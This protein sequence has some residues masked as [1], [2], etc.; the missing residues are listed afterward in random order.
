MKK[1][2]TGRTQ[3]K[4]KENKMNIRN[5]EQ[6]NIYQDKHNKGWIVEIRGLF[7]FCEG[8]FQ[9]HKIGTCGTLKAAKEMAAKALNL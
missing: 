3:H 9:W 5:H 6:V 8:R 1:D 4:R 7:V 2:Q